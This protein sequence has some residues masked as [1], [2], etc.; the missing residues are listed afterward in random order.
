MAVLGEAV[1]EG[2]GEVV[3]F[4]ERSPFAEAQIGSDEGGLLPCAACA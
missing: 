2:G 4:E 1:D 3:V